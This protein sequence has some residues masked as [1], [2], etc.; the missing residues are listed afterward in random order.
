[1]QP[2]GRKANQ[3]E[4]YQASAPRRPAGRHIV[5]P[6]P[7]RKPVRH[8]MRLA[9]GGLRISRKAMIVS[10]LLVMVAGGGV[11]LV[12]SGQGAELIARFAPQLG[13]TITDYAISGNQEVT[14]RTIVAI[15]EPK[16]DMSLLSY[17]AA[18]ARRALIKH[19]WIAE[20]RVSKVY[21]DRL[22]VDIIERPIFALWQSAE[23]LKLIDREGRVLGDYDGRVHEYPLLVGT[24]A[25]TAAATILSRLQRHPA[26]TDQVIALIRIGDR[27]WDLELGNGVIIMLP[28]TGMDE[29]LRRLARLDAER[30]VFSR[31]IDRIDLRLAD[32]ITVK[33]TDRAAELVRAERDEKV[34]AMKTA[35][36]GRQI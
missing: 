30:G 28:E 16:G 27:R 22:A 34:D 33:L 23:G 4:A 1:M 25:N 10:G 12:K 9:N 31:A 20:A 24:G 11:A 29:R 7:L 8:L 17:D 21:P 6:R 14:D 35:G 13:G 19:P 26:I 5:L 15:I 36:R 18:A 3:N 2:I 32:R